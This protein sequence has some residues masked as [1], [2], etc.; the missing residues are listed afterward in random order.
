[1]AGR[2]VRQKTMLALAMLSSG[3]VL[4]GCVTAAERQAQQQE[5]HMQEMAA[6]DDAFC[7]E[8]K[9]QGY[10]ECRRTRLSYRQTMMTGSAAVIVAGPQPNAMQNAGQW[11]QCGKPTC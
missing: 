9:V 3:L 8:Q 11:L 2:G 6:Q 10:D 5:Q 1:M 4:A 7:K